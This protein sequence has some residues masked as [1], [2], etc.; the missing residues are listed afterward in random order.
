MYE[1]TCVTG[2]WNVK[3]KHDNK[4]IEWFN[5]TLKINCT[6]VIFGDKLSI[7]LMKFY[8]QDLPS[9]Y[10]ELDITEFHT[11]KYKN[12]MISHPIHCPSIELNLIWNE[13]IFLIKK[14]YEMNPFN[15]NFFCWV[16]A[17]ICIYRDKY[18]PS[19]LFPNPRK[20]INLPINK[21]I[22][23]SSSS[24][25]EKLVRNN[26]YYHHI[27]GTT[28]ILHKNIIPYFTKLYDTYL[29]K[30][31]DKNNIWTEQV[32]LTHIYKDNKKLFHKLCSGYGTVFDVLK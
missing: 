24:Y 30:L 20:I 15:S 19:K 11:Y 6:Y 14:A 17:G 13:K 1:F 16:D 9:I 25:D 5:K 18:P 27:S 4:F 29:T 8:R 21:F 3:N 23:S 12:K 31:V 10:I 22:Y 28:Y 26:N 7:E 2:Y 32:I